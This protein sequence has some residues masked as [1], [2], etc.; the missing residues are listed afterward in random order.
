MTNK[1]QVPERTDR[2]YPHGSGDR[3]TTS[4]FKPDKTKEFEGGTQR[5]GDPDRPATETEAD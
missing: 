1:D 3:N 5:R 2:E 4:P